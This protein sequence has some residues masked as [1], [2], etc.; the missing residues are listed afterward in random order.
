M[1]EQRME[2][3]MV[4]PTSA[5]LVVHTGRHGE[6]TYETRLHSTQGESS[7]HPIHPIHPIL[8]SY[9]TYVKYI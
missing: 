9:V 5:E 3:T 1:V 6:K 2:R 4:E 8:L 7:M